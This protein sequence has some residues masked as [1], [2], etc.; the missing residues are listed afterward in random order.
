MEFNDEIRIYSKE[1]KLDN[2]YA[3][4][5]K[6]ESPIMLINYFKHQ[7]VRRKN[8]VSVFIIHCLF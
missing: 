8:L 4:T 1:N 3:R 7:L 5:I 2:R 6:M